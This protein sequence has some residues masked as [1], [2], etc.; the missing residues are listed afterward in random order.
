LKKEGTDPRIAAFV[1]RF[2]RPRG[3]AAPVTP[4]MVDEIEQAAQLHKQSRRSALWHY[5]ARA[6]IR[7][8]IAARRMT[9]R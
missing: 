2:I 4:V 1:E 5:L 3:S 7:M 8:A 6:G 9:R